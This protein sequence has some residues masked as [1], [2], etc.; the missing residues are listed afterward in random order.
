[1]SSCCG[2]HREQF[3]GTAQTTP[4]ANDGQ[5]QRLPQPAIQF[6]YVG[7]TAIT[8]LGSVTGQRYR[9][10]HPGSRVHVDPRDAPSVAG[11]PNLR[12]I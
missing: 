10:D 9:F 1:M 4:R 11:V 5:R 7:A 8:V 3:L 12:R 2:R 6:E